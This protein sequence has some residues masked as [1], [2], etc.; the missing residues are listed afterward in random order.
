MSYQDNSWREYEKACDEVERNASTTGDVREWA[1]N[2]LMREKVCSVYYPKGRMNTKIRKLAEQYPD[3]V[4]IAYENN[5]GSI[6]AHLPKSAIKISI[7]KGRQMT[8][9]QKEAA[10]QRIMEYHRR[11]SEGEFDEE[12]EALE[13]ELDED[14]D[15][16]EDPVE[17]ESAED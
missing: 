14:M 8:D 11:K 13:D 5:D 10:R 17:T 1:I 2:G 9:E 3:E 4:K 12:L 15:D 16:D 7:R 6:V